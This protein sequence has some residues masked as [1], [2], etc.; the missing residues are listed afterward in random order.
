MKKL[1]LLSISFISLFSY[2]YAVKPMRPMKPVYI[3][4]NNSTSNF[5]NKMNRESY[6]RD[7]DFYNMQMDNYLDSQN[8]RIQELE[9]KNNFGF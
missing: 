2:S 4:G 7:I 6:E 3:P 9:N 8:R 5:M 1:F